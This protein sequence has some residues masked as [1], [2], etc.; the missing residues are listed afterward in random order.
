MIH[1]GDV[2]SYKDR[3]GGDM[4]DFSSNINPLGPPAGLKDEMDRAY[5]EL[6]AYP[7]IQYRELRQNIADYLGRDTGEVITGNGAVDIIDNLCVMFDRIV[8]ATPCFSE[9]I[10]RPAVYGK[11]V[12]K[13]P[14]DDKFR[15]DLQ[16]L[17]DSLRRGDLLILGN[18]NNPTGLRIPEKTLMHIYD[19]VKQRGAFLLLDEAFF[20]F[21]PPDYDSIE[22]L[23]DADSICVVRAA[24]KVFALPGIRL[25]YGWASREFAGRYRGIENPWSVNAYANAAGRCIFRDKGYIERTREYIN[26]ERQY[27]TDGLREIEWIRPYGSDANFMLLKLFKYDEDMVFDRLIRNGIMIRKASSFEGLNK[28]YIRIAV[29]DRESNRKLMGFLREFEQ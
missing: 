9:Y 13:L 29:K 10:S 7:D 20:E 24:T 18:P 22:L 21:C 27:L 17:A 11:Q 12:L 25:G 3:Y 14:L 19:I 2:V 15:I 23:H 6:R 8:T 4:I 26:R 1:G 16:A 28:T 5:S